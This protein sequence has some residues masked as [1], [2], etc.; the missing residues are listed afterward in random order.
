MVPNHL[1]LRRRPYAT[2]RVAHASAKSRC[3]STDQFKS[4]TRT[5]VPCAVV[6]SRES[7]HGPSCC[8]R[9]KM[10]S[11][12]V[13]IGLVVALS[14][15]GTPTVSW[16]Q[17]SAKEDAKKAGEKTKDAGKAAGDAA[18]EGGKAV[19]KT[20]K[21][22]GE[23]A[24]DVGEATGDAAKDVGKATKDGAE[25]VKNDVTGKTIK[26]KC[27]DGTTQSGKSAATACEKHG[28]PAAKK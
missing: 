26:A 23:G 20:G 15:V 3:K 24:K 1:S 17:D 21:A 14:A 7:P 13:T 4:R 19:G 22:V 16:A 25:G 10:R 2:R 8:R 6:Y 18:K 9:A 12:L 5:R 11:G 28:G 27:T